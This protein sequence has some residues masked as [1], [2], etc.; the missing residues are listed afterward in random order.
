M[1]TFEGNQVLGSPA[2]IQKLKSVGPVDIVGLSTVS[3]LVEL[4]NGVDVMYY[5]VPTYFTILLSL[6]RARLRSSKLP[7]WNSPVPLQE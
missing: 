3:I 2:I 1:L 6:F 5:H 7:L 4:P